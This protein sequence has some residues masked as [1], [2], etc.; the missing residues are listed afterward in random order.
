MPVAA[1]QSKPIDDC[2]LIKSAYINMVDM[3]ILM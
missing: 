2:L 3:N 1:P